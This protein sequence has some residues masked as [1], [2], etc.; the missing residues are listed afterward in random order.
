MPDALIAPEMLRLEILSGS[1]GSQSVSARVS[2][3]LLKLL[4]PG[5]VLQVKAATNEDG[6]RGI[7]YQGH[8]IPVAVPPEIAD[9]QVLVIRVAGS[10]EALLLQLLEVRPLDKLLDS[11]LKLPGSDVRRVLPDAI[12]QTL[13]ELLRET[14]KA[15]KAENLQLPL[16]LDP[17]PAGQTNLRAERS[18]PIVDRNNVVQSGVPP[19][20]PLETSS[21]AAA[22]PVMPEQTSQQR[23]TEKAGAVERILQALIGQKIVATVKELGSS[24]DLQRFLAVNALSILSA[25]TQEATE[26]LQ[27]L[28]KLLGGS[29]AP[30]QDRIKSALVESLRTLLSY[31]TELSFSEQAKSAPAPF[32]HKLYL[33]AVAAVLAPSLGIKELEHLRQAVLPETRANPLLFLLTTLTSF[34]F[35]PQRQS[36]A[37]PESQELGLIQTLISELERLRDSKAGDREIRQGLQRMLA[38][39][40]KEPSGGSQLSSAAKETAARPGLQSLQGML[41][42]RESLSQL[43]PIMQSAGQPVLMII[44]A[45]IQGILSRWE[46]VFTPRPQPADGE[47]GEKKNE[48]EQFE[49]V[50]LSIP[51]PSLG[52]VQIELA[53]RSGEILVHFTLAKPEM[54]EFV[55]RRLPELSLMLQ[56]AGYRK[57]Q[58]HAETGL[59]GHVSAWWESELVKGLAIA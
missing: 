16:Q 36:T 30:Q 33:E 17:V 4:P 46:M 58:L 35:F 52:N 8:F 28:V 42:S 29:A 31:Q 59:P 25:R 26:A 40:E 56:S 41:E 15:T 18:R 3:A 34:S 32:A 48:S 37:G 45:L 47:G 43:N 10:Q 53:R 27:D 24:E 19:A 23:S 7:V 44:P 12:E 20:A 49:R 57:A 14:S 54:T 6:Q 39:V 13:R 50:S 2:E 38:Q 55:R 1:A 51:L 5:A 11:V 9:G 21:F 22:A